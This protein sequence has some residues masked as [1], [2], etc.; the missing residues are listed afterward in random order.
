[1]DRFRLENIKDI[2]VGDLP[3]AKKGI[4]DSLMGKDSLKEEI[5]VEHMASYKQGHQLGTEIENLL[6]GDESQY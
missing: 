6:K 1:M 4:I 3:A 5:P 2:H